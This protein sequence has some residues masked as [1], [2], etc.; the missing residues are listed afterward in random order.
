MIKQPFRDSRR[1]VFRAFA[2]AFAQLTPL[3]GFLTRIYQVTH[4]SK[5]EKDR[6]RWENEITRELNNLLAP[7]SQ[8]V[9]AWGRISF[10]S[11]WIDDGQN[12]SSVADYGTGDV[13]INLATIP[14]NDYQISIE[15]N[16]ATIDIVEKSP[17]GF[18]VKIEKCGLPAD[19][20]FQFVVTSLKS[21][22]PKLVLQ[23]NS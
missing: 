14:D 20:P 13:F 23:N 3:T 8:G 17:S 12:I 5:G 19:L 10:E 22:A 6:Q 11:G 9:F 16:G 18:R 15:P 21:G 7:S 2:E 4:P 1:D